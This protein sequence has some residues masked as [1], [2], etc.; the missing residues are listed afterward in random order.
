MG[1]PKNGPVTKKLEFMVV[2]QPF[3]LGGTEVEQLQTYSHCVFE[4][5]TSKSDQ[6]ALKGPFFGGGG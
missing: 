4:L 1:G 2:Y 6:T 5:D 3:T